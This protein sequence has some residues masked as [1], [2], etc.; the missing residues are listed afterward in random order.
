MQTEL[1]CGTFLLLAVMPLSA[2]RTVTTRPHG[3]SVFPDHQTSVKQ[4]SHAQQMSLCNKTTQ[5]LVPLNSRTGTQS[6]T[7]IWQNRPTWY[8]YIQAVPPGNSKVTNRA[9]TQQ[10]TF[11]KGLHRWEPAQSTDTMAPVSSIALNNHLQLSLRFSHTM[12][13]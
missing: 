12:L 3:G 10:F 8:E 4:G 11:K 13:P 7:E 6:V 1:Q 9:E 2:A 5:P